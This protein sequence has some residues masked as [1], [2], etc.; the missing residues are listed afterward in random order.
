MHIHASSMHL[1]SASLNSAA[2]AR[3]KWINSASGAESVPS[4][5]EA[6][7]IGQWMNS[8]NN[9]APV[10]TGNEP[11]HRT[12]AVGKGSDFARGRRPG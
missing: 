11:V 8:R 12:A 2:D 4:P 9:A 1:H 3:R 5:D 6:F 7:M 10:P